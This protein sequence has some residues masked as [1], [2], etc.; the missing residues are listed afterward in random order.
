VFNRRNP[1]LSIEPNAILERELRFLKRIVPRFD[2]RIAAAGDEPGT[3]TL[4]VPFYRG[5]PLTA[6]SS[7]SRDDLVDERGG[8]R[9]RLGDR[10]DSPDFHI[11]NVTA[12]VL[13]LDD[14]ALSPDFVKIDVEGAE[15]RVLR[16]LSDTLERSHPILLIERSGDFPAIRDL[17]AASDYLPYTYRRD[18]GRFV[19]FEAVSPGANVFFLQ[20][21][22]VRVR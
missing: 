6:Y 17:L 8:L 10:V 2:Y 7:S 14:L 4:F 21:D 22:A 13:R 19:A 5:V 15:L 20:R 9:D 12:E 18:V 16:G 11:E 1:I 3:M